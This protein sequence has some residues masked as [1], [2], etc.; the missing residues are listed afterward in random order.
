MQA[1]AIAS[2]SIAR[3]TC[4]GN[5]LCVCAHAPSRTHSVDVDTPQADAG[6]RGAASPT[7]SEEAAAEEEACAIIFL[8]SPSLHRH[9]HACTAGSIRGMSYS[10][11]A[12]NGQ[13]GHGNGGEE[14]SG[15]TMFSA[16]PEQCV[17][18]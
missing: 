13:A 7:C 11:C 6:C 10:A 8:L 18:E 1:S 15:G 4:N 2:M 12:A 5:S 16:A 17:N 14:E 9:A 3:A